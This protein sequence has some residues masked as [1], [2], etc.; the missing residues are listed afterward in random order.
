MILKCKTN[1]QTKTTNQ[2]CIVKRRKANDFCL[3]KLEKW[4]Y[5]EKWSKMRAKLGSQVL[6]TL[7]LPRRV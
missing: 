4:K 5:R 7:R 6:A 2:V 1:K 3:R